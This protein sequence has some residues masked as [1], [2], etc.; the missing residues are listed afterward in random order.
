L[1]PL[2]GRR[3]VLAGDEPGRHRVPRVVDL[4]RPGRQPLSES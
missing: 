2:R 3:A 1:L 4:G